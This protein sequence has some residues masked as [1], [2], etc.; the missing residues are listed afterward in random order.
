MYCPECG[1]K[2]PD[3]GMFCPECGARMPQRRVPSFEAPAAD[4]ARNTGGAQNAG[5]EQ[6]TGGQQTAARGVEAGTSAAPK[7]W[8]EYITP[9]NME[10][11][12]AVTPLI[13]LFMLVVS[14]ALSILLRI[15]WRVPVIDPVLSFVIRLIRVVFV[16][17]AAAGAAAA[18]YLIANDPS[19]RN[20]WGGITLGMAVAA[21]VACLGF[22]LRWKYVPGVLTVITVLWGIDVI[23][24]VILQK[25]GMESQADL[26][27]D[28]GA[29]RSCF[30]QY[31]AEQPAKT[32]GGKQQAVFDPNGSYFDGDGGT[33]F[34]LILLTALVGMFTCGIAVP[35]MLC[36]VYTWRKEHTVINGRRLMFNGTGADLFGHWIL[37][38]ILCVVTCGI[39]AFFMHVALRKWEMNHTFYAD[40]PD[41]A[42]QFDGNSVEYFGYGLIQGLLLMITC[43]LAA[44]WT[45]TMITKWETQH[46]VVAGDRMRYTGTAMELLGQYLI[47]ALLSVIT[48][49][50]YSAWGIVRLNKYI[51]SHTCVDR[52]Y[53]AV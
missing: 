29:Y 39:Y 6:Y 52:T 46:C 49:G 15:F 36:K 24:R 23:S 33:L 43:G 20:L 21:F 11:L 40:R 47:V 5:R 2:V 26:A 14:F 10:I 48:C 25:K 12:A 19:K 53:V 30:E 8:R 4:G 41:L 32:A 44:P 34:G 7:N 51:Y 50:I 31:R 22:L 45:I 18:G 13:P 16:L 27:A 3:G 42:G 17:A 1:R 37:W 9:G 35:W 38:E 28:A